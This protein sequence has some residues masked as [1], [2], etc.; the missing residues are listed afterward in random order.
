M[1]TAA[2]IVAAGRGQRFQ[3]DIPKAFVTLA[4]DP[5]LVHVARR[6]FASGS[7][8]EICVVGPSGHLDRC[9]SML[10]DAVAGPLRVVAGGERRQDSVR[11]GLYSLSEEADLVAVHDAARPLVPR[12]LILATIAAARAH[13]AAIAAVPVTDSVKEVSR[14]GWISAERPR[15][16]LW[17]AQ[18][19]QCFR[20]EILREAYRQAEQDGVEATDDASLVL[21]LGTPIRIVPGDTSNLKITYPEDLRLAEALLALGHAGKP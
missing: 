3:S 14:D 17:L 13:G 6:F 9:R 10:T 18:T 5:L 15:Q 8:E 7:V 20:R 11:A 2:I 21:R 12:D 4:G 1:T 19:P 16:G